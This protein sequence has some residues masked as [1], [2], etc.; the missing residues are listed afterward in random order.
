MRSRPPPAGRGDR[1]DQMP[2]HPGRSAP[3]EPGTSLG[4]WS[5]GTPPARRP[6]DETRAPATL[7]D[8]TLRAIAD[9]GSIPA[10]ST[11][12]RRTDNPGRTC[13]SRSFGAGFVATRATSFAGVSAGTWPIESQASRGWLA[14]ASRSAV[15][16]G[17]CSATLASVGDCESARAPDWD[18]GTSSNQARHGQRAGR[19]HCV[20]ERK[21]RPSR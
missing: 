7:V 2:A 15:A 16:A 4:S 19:S 11:G 3:A 6:R 18:A 14:G 10:V 1:R 17:T 5:R 12:S 8:A 13:K 20:P 9:A 21:R